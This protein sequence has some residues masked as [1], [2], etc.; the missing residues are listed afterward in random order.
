MGMNVMFLTGRVGKSFWISHHSR[1]EDDFTS[2][3]LHCT[4]RKSLTIKEYVKLIYP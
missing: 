4:E 1:I 2:H 3:W